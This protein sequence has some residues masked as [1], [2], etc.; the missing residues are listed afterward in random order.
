MK[1]HTDLERFGKSS[2]GTSSKVAELVLE[3]RPGD[4]RLLIMMLHRHDAPKGKKKISKQGDG[5]ENPKEKNVPGRK[6]EKAM[7]NITEKSNSR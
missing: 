1:K 6:E 7:S 4:C 2:K 5:M 3:Y